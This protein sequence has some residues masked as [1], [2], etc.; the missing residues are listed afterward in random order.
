LEFL[1][2]LFSVKTRGFDWM[3]ARL[4]LRFASLFVLLLCAVWNLQMG[5]AAML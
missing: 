5:L 3:A 4:A 2:V 1:K